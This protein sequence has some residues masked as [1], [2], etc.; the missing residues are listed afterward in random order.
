MIIGVDLGGTNIRAGLEHEGSIIRQESRLLVDKDS[1]SSTLQ[2]LIELIKPLFNEEITGIG[3]GVPSVVDV[4][5]G[6]VYDVVNIPSWKKVALKDILE[7]EFGVPV[8]VNNDV[9]CFT[10]GEF[11]FGI[12]QSFS[13]LVG[14]TLGTGLGSGIIV[15]GELH[16]GH[17]CGAGE[18]GMLPY[19]D[20]NFEHYTSGRFFELLHGISARKAYEAALAGD[21]TA[22]SQWAEFGTHLGQVVKAILYTYDPQAIVLGGSITK[23]YPFFKYAMLEAIQDFAYPESIRNLNVL[24]TQN[25]N[26]ALLGAAAL[27][28]AQL[29]KRVASVSTFE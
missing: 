3:V 11:H 22:L 12:G 1:L 27:A 16:A 21:R 13:S 17:N 19:L 4:E 25:D 26:I 6:I 28:H 10:L 24:Q 29:R 18:I 2:Q 8:F 23:A 15:N 9:N 20:S 5:K 7:K 14:I